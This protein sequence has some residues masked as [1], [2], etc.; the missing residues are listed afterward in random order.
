MRSSL[1]DKNRP[2]VFGL[3]KSFW[4]D[5]EFFMKKF[6]IGLLLSLVSVSAFANTEAYKTLPDEKATFKLCESASNALNNQTLHIT[7]ALEIFEPYLGRSDDEIELAK[8]NNQVY[9][10]QLLDSKIGNPVSTIHLDTKKEMKDS[11]LTHRFLLKRERYML[12][13]MCT[14]YQP[15]ENSHWKLA[16]FAIFTP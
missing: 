7:P 10:V 4:A 1:I 8:V 3:F 9:L 6:I 12:G 5:L 11:L 15:K 14:F 13:L 2:K 16:N